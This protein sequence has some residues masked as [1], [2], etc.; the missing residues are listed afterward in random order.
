VQLVLIVTT[1]ELSERGSLRPLFNFGL[2]DDFLRNFVLELAL[3]Q[4]WTKALYPHWRLL[5][6]SLLAVYGAC[7]IGTFGRWR[8]I[9]AVLTL[10]AC[11]FWLLGRIRFGDAPGVPMRVIGGSRFLYLPF[12][13]CVWSLA[14]TAEKATATAR[15]AA[16]LLLL[17]VALNSAS[18]FRRPPWPPTC[19]E[20]ISTADGVLYRITPPPS[21]AFST[22]VKGR[23]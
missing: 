5:G 2:T 12:V 19:V 14:I 1:P 17:L 23:N 9:C 20:R 6:A 7:L 13:L 3:S 8:R 18:L 22:T 10:G 4:E 15:T 21:T 16:W 11:L